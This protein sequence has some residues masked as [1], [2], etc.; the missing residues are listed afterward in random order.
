LRELLEEAFGL[1]EEIH[2]RHWNFFYDH[3][4]LRYL[5]EL[6]EN[7][8]AQLCATGIVLNLLTLRPEISTLLLIHDPAWYARISA[9]DGDMPFVTAEETQ[10]DS[11]VMASIATDAEFLSHFP[12]DLHLSMP[13]QATATMWLGIDLA[14]RQI[15]SHA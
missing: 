15:A 4:A 2:P 9:A 7:G 12:P 8:R 13:A 1:P 10:A 14:R 6:F 3:P 11:V 5:L